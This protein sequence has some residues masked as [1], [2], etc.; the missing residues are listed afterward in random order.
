MGSRQSRHEEKTPCVESIQP[1]KSHDSERRKSAEEKVNGREHAYREENPKFA[2]PKDI[3][4]VPRLHIQHYLIR[5]LWQGNFSS[6]VGEVLSRPDAK[7]LDLGCGAGTWALELAHEYPKAEITGVDISN[8][9]PTNHST[10]NLNFIELD[11]LKTPKLPFNDNIFDLVHMRF[12]LADIK[13]QDYEDFAIKELIRVTKPGGWIEIVEFDVQHY[14]DGPSTRRLTNALN[15][16]L[17]SKGYNG[18]ISEKIPNFL[19]QTGQVNAIKKHEK[20]IPLG[21]WAGRVG[22]LAIENLSVLFRETQELSQSMGLT[23]QEYEELISVY[24]QEVEERCTFFKTHRFYVQKLNA[25]SEII[26]EK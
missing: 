22:D 21:H 14:S 6:P 23:T 19:K 11:F 10:P 8:F 12:L 13:E 5:F 1:R 7:V 25:A 16:H 3:N 24:K 2:I 9:F 18:Q 26:N 15:Q 20:S 4:G 17:K